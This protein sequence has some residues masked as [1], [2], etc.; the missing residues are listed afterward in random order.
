MLKLVTHLAEDAN[1]ES[2]TENIDVESSK[3]IESSLPHDI[4]KEYASK[5][6]LLC[7]RDDTER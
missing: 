5:V 7:E 4:S 3:G 1:A 6:H 2:S